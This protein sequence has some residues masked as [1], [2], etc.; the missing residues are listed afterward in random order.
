[1]S[2]TTVSILM[3]VFN[4]EATLAAAVTSVQAQSY[5]NWELIL[6]DDGSTDGSTALAER[7]VADDPRL[8]LHVLSFNQGAARARNEAL[9]HANGPLIAF[10]DADDTWMPQ[11]LELQVTAMQQSGAAFSYTGYQRCR[12][13]QCRDVS[14][15][16]SLSYDQLLRGNV[17]GCLTAMY[18]SSKLGKRPMPDLRMRQDF[19]L[20]LEI[21]REDPVVVG[22]P[23]MLAT[24]NRQKGSLSSGVLR[25]MAGTWAVYRRVE[26]L[27]VGRSIGLISR[28][29]LNRITSIYGK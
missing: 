8:K 2:A 17:V 20:W 29:Y 22:L 3:P 25:A 24:H 6:V 12:D 21:L 16:T 4:A 7:L 27:S 11:K 18:D 13:G 15:P 10:L 23:E 26:G 19:A 5:R 14:V 1:M 9:A 28:H